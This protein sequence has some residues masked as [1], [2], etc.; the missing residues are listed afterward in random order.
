MRARSG[1]GPHVGRTP[2]PHRRR[3]HLDRQLV[4]QTALLNLLN[5]VDDAVL[6]FVC[7]LVLDGFSIVQLPLGA[8]P[9]SHHS[10]TLKFYSPLFW[11]ISFD[12]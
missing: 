8:V 2:G 7:E 5:V 11:E 12:C 3:E 9:D 4:F 1:V 10:S 6:G